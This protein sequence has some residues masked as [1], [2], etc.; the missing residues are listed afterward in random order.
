MNEDNYRNNTW[1]DKKNITI[2]CVERLGLNYIFLA[3]IFSFVMQILTQ[4][5]YRTS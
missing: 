2:F 5:V 1:R 4:H 3:N